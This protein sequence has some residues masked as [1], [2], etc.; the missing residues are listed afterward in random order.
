[1]KE[2]DAADMRQTRMITGYLYFVENSAF[3][4]SLTSG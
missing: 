2:V 1:M 3:Q 4:E